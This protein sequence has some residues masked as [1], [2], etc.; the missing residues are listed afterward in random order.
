MSTIPNKQSS[1]G[2]WL[3]GILALFVVV[4]L[5]SF[6]SDVGFCPWAHGAFRGGLTGHWAAKLDDAPGTLVEL[7]IEHRWD[8]NTGYSRYSNPDG[9]GFDAEGKLATCDTT[10]RREEYPIIID[11][12]NYTGTRFELVFRGRSPAFVQNQVGYEI[13]GERQGNRLELKWEERGETARERSVGRS[14]GLT[15]DA[16]ACNAR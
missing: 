10:G 15:R 11:R 7:S 14:L 8:W 4:A 12:V 5:L 3:K 9:G 16:R 2:G 6:A 13:Q 1:A